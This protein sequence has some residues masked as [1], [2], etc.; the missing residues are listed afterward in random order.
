MNENEK[1]H[2]LHCTK[3]DDGILYTGVHGGKERVITERGTQLATRLQC[4]QLFIIT[5]VTSIIELD[6]RHFSSSRTHPQ[7]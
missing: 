1:K 5:R 4:L 2:T 3:G 6:F 7:I